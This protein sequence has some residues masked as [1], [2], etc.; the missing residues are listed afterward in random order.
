MWSLGLTIIEVAIGHYPFPPETYSNVFAQ[1][2]A[3]V[4]GDPPTLPERYS[5][6]AQ[7]FVAQCLRKDARLRPSYQQLLEHPWLKGDVQRD[8]DMVGWVERGIAYRKENPKISV[9]ALA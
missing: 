4:H 5:P 3:I 2:T 8:V 7:D 6:E 9:P 1:L